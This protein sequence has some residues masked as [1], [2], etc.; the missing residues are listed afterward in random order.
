MHTRGGGRRAGQR[1]S[2]LASFSGPSARLRRR[3]ETEGEEGRRGRGS[4]KVSADEGEGNPHRPPPPKGFLSISEDVGGPTVGL[5]VCCHPMASLIVR[6]VRSFPFPP[7]L[8]SPRP[9][10]GWGL[11]ST[12]RSRSKTWSLIR[13]NSSLL[14]LA[15]V[16]TSLSSPWYV[17]SNPRRVRA[18]LGTCLLP[19][20]SPHPGSDSLLRGCW[21][22]WVR[23]RS[24]GMARILPHVPAAASVSG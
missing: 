3:E 16:E 20:P 2:P 18:S 4:G 6:S 21:A 15:P 23:R 10:P 7:C 9:L 24:Y 12:K 1:E 8:S 13:P 19:Y 14:T 22:G 17:C 5:L 11:L